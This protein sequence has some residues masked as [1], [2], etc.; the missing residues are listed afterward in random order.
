[1]FHHCYKFI[2][3]IYLDYLL[4]Y[5]LRYYIRTMQKAANKNLVNFSELQFTLLA[6]FYCEDWTIYP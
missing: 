3:L 1:M 6:V 5:L 4:D 2:R